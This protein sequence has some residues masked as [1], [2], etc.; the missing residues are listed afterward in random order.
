VD[1]NR[2]IDYILGL[3]P[4]IRFW[5]KVVALGCAGMMA[6]NEASRRGPV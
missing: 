2:Y 6:W 1:G 5:C 4:I 3:G